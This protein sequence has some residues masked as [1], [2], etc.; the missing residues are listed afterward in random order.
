MPHEAR[1]SSKLRTFA[2]FHV[3]PFSRVSPT[4]G[5]ILPSVQYICPRGAPSSD[6]RNHAADSFIDSPS[7]F[8]HPK[9]L[10]LHYAT[11]EDDIAPM[12]RVRTRRLYAMLSPD[13]TNANTRLIITP[14]QHP[15]QYS[16]LITRY[17]HD[18]KPGLEDHRQV[19]DGR[20]VRRLAARRAPVRDMRA[21]RSALGG[22]AGR[23]GGGTF[24]QGPVRGVRAERSTIRGVR[25]QGVGLLG[26][27]G[28]HRGRR[29]AHGACSDDP[30]PAGGHPGT[31][32]RR[33]IWN[34]ARDRVVRGQPSGQHRRRRER[35][36]AVHHCSPA[37]GPFTRARGGG[38]RGSHRGRTKGGRPRRDRSRHGQT[39][40][41]EGGRRAPP[42]ASDGAD[43]PRRRG[44]TSE[45]SRQDVRAARRE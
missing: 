34:A 7:P 12:I 45:G 33:G 24:H 4:D 5:S 41:R 42:S 32:R 30:L 13:C 21:H 2:R 27:R 18:L 8:Y 14:H 38:M 6:T 37:A 39:L 17:P 29:H 28:P 3:R 10:P 31:P 26:L 1:S 23:R 25:P 35:R 20:G 22:D 11:S 36:R 19:A 15:A 16:L 43:P 44:Q 9:F 40:E